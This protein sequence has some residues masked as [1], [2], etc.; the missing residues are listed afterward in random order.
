MNPKNLEEA[1]KAAGSPVD[2]PR[3]SQMGPNV[4]PVI[5]AEY[6]NWRS[7]QESW[8]KTCAL[9][10]LSYHMNDMYIEGPDAL[11]L[12]SDHGTNTFKNYGVDKAKQYVPCTADGYVI[13]DVILFHLAENLYNV[14]GRASVHNWL[15]YNA[16]KGKYNVKLERDERTAVR[17]GPVVRKVYRYQ[18]QGPNAPQVTQ[19]LLGQPAPELKFF[20]M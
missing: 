19:K 15:Q 11:K 5:P 1:I 8:Q 10:T 7:E 12:I 13:G 4:Y 14:V 2:L 20:N 9:F 16:E 6:S 18:L 17:K 3:N